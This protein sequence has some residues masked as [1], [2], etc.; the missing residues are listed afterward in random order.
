[1]SK[2]RQQSNR[3]SNSNGKRKSRVSRRGADTAKMI[4]DPGKR[5]EVIKG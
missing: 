2:R 1:V 3:G 5:E 4:K